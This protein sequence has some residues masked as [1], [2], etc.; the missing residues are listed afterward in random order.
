MNTSR[1]TARCEGQRGGKGSARLEVGHALLW[2]AA[3]VGWLPLARSWRPRSMICRS[4]FKDLGRW[5]LR[6]GPLP[7]R[8]LWPQPLPFP[9]WSGGMETGSTSVSMSMRVAGLPWAIASSRPW[10]RMSS[11]LACGLCLRRTVQRHV[12]VQPRAAKAH[13][14]PPACTPAAHPGIKQQEAPGQLT[15]QAFSALVF[16]CFSW[17]H[18]CFGRAWMTC[19]RRCATHLRACVCVCV[20]VPDVACVACVGYGRYETVKLAPHACERQCVRAAART[21]CTPR[22][23]PWQCEDS[24]A[25]GATGSSRPTAPRA[26]AKP[27]QRRRTHPTASVGFTIAVAQGRHWL[28]F[29]SAGRAGQG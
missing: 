5:S 1:R 17:T 10:A 28:G 3:G 4:A 2:R 24:T 19:C 12:C 27:S 14:H 18:A 21:A 29:L 25:P 6:Q 13:T 16:L 15:A 20:R 23:A 26:R 11:S 8:T 7:A 22:D 9:T